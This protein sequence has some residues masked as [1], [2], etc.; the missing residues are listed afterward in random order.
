MLAHTV[1]AKRFYN[2][3]AWKDCRRSYIS[4]VFGLCER[5]SQPCDIV[6]HKVYIDSKNIND[7]QVT[8][9]HD[10][11]EALCIQCHNKEHF[12]KY[13]SIRDGFSFNE[14]GELVFSP[15]R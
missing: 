4:K 13:E 7:V 12:K 9:N 2:S 5:C 3:K 1:E 8:L 15:D 14:K 10:N 6:H 11:L